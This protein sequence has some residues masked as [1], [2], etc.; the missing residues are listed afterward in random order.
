MS[1]NQ[2]QDLHFQLKYVVKQFNKNSTR[3]EKEQKAELGKCKKAMAKG[4]MDIARIFAENSIRKRNESLSHLRLASRMDAV[5]SRLDT[6]IKMNKVTRGMSQM[7]HGMDKVVQSMNPEKISEL[8]EKFEKQFETMDVASE[9]METAIGQTT[10]TS[11]PEDEVSLL[12]LQVAEEEG[13]AVKEELFNK[14]KL[15]QQQPVAPEATKSAEPDL[16]ELSAR[17]DML[18]GK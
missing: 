9:Y 14:A 2:L 10:S 4:N 1:V 8:M 17:L 11:M 7:V 13:L 16:D 15:P 12:L 5:V 6:A 3:C 18:R